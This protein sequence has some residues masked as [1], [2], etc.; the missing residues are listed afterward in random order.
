MPGLLKLWPLLCPFHSGKHM[1]HCDDQAC[2]KRLVREWEIPTL[3]DV[4]CILGQALLQG[5]RAHRAEAGRLIHLCRFTVRCGPARQATQPP[6]SS[7]LIPRL[8][9]TLISTSR[10]PYASQD[11]SSAN[12]I[13]LTQ[14]VL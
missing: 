13:R 5:L 7:L 2:Q 14:A 3:P 12:L 6:P 9:P 10:R 4:G 8:L 11:A 1:S